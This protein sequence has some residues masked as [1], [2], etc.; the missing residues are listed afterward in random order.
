MADR[1]SSEKRSEIMSKVRSKWT[2][3]EKIIHNSLKGNRI[4][5]KMHPR[6]MGSPDVLITETNTL[7]FIDGCFWHGCRKH[8]SLPK[9]RLEYWESKIK[10][11]VKRDAMNRRKLRK[12]GYNV[13]RIWEH[14]INDDS[15]NI[16]RFLQ[17]KLHNIEHANS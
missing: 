14:Q 4:R 5:H 1:V 7:I 12:I 3:P 8:C 17:K 16:S 10:G 11:N 2:N 6:I 9:S 15:F 13:I